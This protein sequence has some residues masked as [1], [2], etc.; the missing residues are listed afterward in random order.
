MAH[1]YNFQ[2]LAVQLGTAHYHLTEGHKAQRRPHTFGPIVTLTASASCST[3]DSM[4]ALASTPNR[5]SLAA[6]PRFS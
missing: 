2:A 3:P 5:M 1:F 6:Y 4:P